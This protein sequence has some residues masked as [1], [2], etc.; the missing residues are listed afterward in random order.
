MSSICTGITGSRL[1]DYGK[2]DEAIYTWLK[3]CNIKE[4]LLV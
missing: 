3:E 2:N 1:G 4:N